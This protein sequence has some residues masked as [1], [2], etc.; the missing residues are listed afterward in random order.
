[1]QITGDELSC[2]GVSLSIGELTDLREAARNFRE[3][4]LCNEKSN[5]FF[6]FYQNIPFCEL[7]PAIFFPAE[8]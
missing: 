4:K 2:V 5:F 3:S 1:M 6:L 7:V 8:I